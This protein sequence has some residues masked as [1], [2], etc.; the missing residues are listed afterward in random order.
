MFKLKF[1]KTTQKSRCALFLHER[2]R[3]LTGSMVKSRT[4]GLLVSA[5]NRPIS[6][7]WLS[8]LL[9]VHLAPINVIISD[10]P[11]NDSLSWGWLPA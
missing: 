8:A 6:T 2:P 11:D 5:E 10:G 7:P 1:V 3:L 4:K 9:R